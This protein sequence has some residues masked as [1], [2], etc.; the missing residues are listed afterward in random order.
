MIIAIIFLFF[1]LI[2]IPYLVF[3]SFAKNEDF[4]KYNGLV[5]FDIDGTLTPNSANYN[6][7]LVQTCIN[8][9]FAV[10]ICTANRG[11][12][13]K[14][15]LTFDWMPNNLYNFIIKQKNITFNNVGSQVLMGKTSKDYS[16]LLHQHPG[17]LKGFALEKTANTLGIINP[18]CMILCDDDNGYIEYA[19]KYKSDINIVNCGTERLNTQNLKKSMLKCLKL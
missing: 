12:S 18:S 6:F 2:I 9:N 16:N 13:M 3:F 19:L 4:K 17:Y 5:L 7:S 10:G 14:N 8:E 1:S 15:L 11:Y